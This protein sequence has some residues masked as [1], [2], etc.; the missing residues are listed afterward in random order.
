MSA[1]GLIGHWLSS[2]HD[3]YSYVDL[4]FDGSGQL[5]YV[6]RYD[7]SGKKEHYKMPLVWSTNKIKIGP[8]E[9][10]NP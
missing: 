8:R 10:W 1:E 7:G 2:L 4:E 3:S 5:I 9:V 6:Y